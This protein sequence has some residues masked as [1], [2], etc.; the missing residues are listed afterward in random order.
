MLTRIPAPVPEREYSD[1]ERLMLKF[2]LSQ[3]A[4][5]H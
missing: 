1:H 4:Y 5:R 3:Q 2:V